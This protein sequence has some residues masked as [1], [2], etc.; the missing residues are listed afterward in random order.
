M[1]VFNSLAAS[2][3]VIVAVA[4]HSTIST[5]QSWA[6]A[7][8]SAVPTQLRRDSDAAQTLKSV[9]LQGR[10]AFPMGRKGGKQVETT[11]QNTI[12]PAFCRKVI[13]GLIWPIR[14]FWDTAPYN[15]CQGTQL[16]LIRQAWE[17]LI[18]FGPIWSASESLIMTICHRSEKYLI[19]KFLPHLIPPISLSRYLLILSLYYL[20][21]LSIHLIS[22][23]NII[24]I[25]LPT[26]RTTYLR[27]GL[28]NYEVHSYLYTKM[29]HNK[30]YHKYII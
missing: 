14:L 25:V 24:I 8:E 29:A 23:L 7:A 30:V 4:Q 1:K 15:G 3:L 27:G 11:I 12:P 18:R 16:S 26:N 6:A 2:L 19:C 10:R 13:Y 17:S 5:G 20:I 9:R 22:F 21:F 28:L